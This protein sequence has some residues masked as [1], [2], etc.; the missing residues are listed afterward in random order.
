M[1]SMNNK[2]TFNNNTKRKKQLEA[3]FS[4]ARRDYLNE[5]NKLRNRYQQVFNSL[6]AAYKAEM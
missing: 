3:E 5:L 4:A 1:I 6:L 2:Q